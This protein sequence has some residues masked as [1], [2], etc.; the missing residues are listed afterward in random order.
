MES[1]C[2]NCGSVITCGCQRRMTK[3]GKPACTNCLSLQ[4]KEEDEERKR[5]VSEEILKLKNDV[6]P[7]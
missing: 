3:E 4:E 7:K 2:L 1:K 5:R 6:L